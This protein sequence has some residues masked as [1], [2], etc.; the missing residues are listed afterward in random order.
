MVLFFNLSNN[1]LLKHNNNENLKTTS[2]IMY[3]WFLLIL[4][5]TEF[6]YMFNAVIT[7]LTI[8]SILIHMGASTG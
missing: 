4:I 8:L 6:V 2:N 1:I 3:I 5:K 7:M